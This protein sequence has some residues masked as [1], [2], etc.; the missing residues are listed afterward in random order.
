MSVKISEDR[1]SIPMKLLVKL[2]SFLFTFC[3]C[4]PQYV[5]IWLGLNK[6]GCV[7][8]LVN[9]GLKG[10]ALHHA[11]TCTDPKIVILSANC[12]PNYLSILPGILASLTKSLVLYEEHPWTV[13]SMH[14]E[15]DLPRFDEAIAAMSTSQ[16]FVKNPPGHRDIL[17]YMFTSGTT[18]LPKPC[19][20]TSQR[21]YIYALSHRYI[22]TKMQSDDVLYC[23]LPLY[24]RLV[25][26]EDTFDGVFNVDSA[27]LED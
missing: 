10:Q 19:I 12:L 1:S 24:H 5:A 15:H 25:N 3:Y 2:L 17:C 8:S 21:A 9:A 18:G 22:V 11:I 16:P 23:T 14:D 27:V 26:C 7:T 6:I 20:V 4:S 13:P